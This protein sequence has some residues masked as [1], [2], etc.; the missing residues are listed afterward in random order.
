M[1]R[2]GSGPSFVRFVPSYPSVVRCSSPGNGRCRL[3]VGVKELRKR[4]Q[5]TASPDARRPSARRGRA[6]ARQTHRRLGVP[7]AGCCAPPRGA[8]HCL[9]PGAAGPSPHALVELSAPRGTSVVR[10]VRLPIL[11]AS[12]REQIRADPSPYLSSDLTLTAPTPQ[13]RLSKRLPQ[14]KLGLELPLRAEPALARLT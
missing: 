12:G 8:M 14:N 9:R 3:N 7:G 4:T 1:S 10:I 13:A 5:R 6:R 11:P 2:A